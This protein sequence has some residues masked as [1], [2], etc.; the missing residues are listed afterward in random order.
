MIILFLI[1]SLEILEPSSTSQNK[2][3]SYY[4]SDLAKNLDFA[5]NLD[6][7]IAIIINHYPYLNDILQEQS[8]DSQD[9]L[10]NMIAIKDQK[11]KSY[12]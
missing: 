5:M 4:K 2:S 8:Q 11:L 10:Y 7:A 12:T 6:L 1:Q 3:T 9:N